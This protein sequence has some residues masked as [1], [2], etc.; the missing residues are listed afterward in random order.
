MAFVGSP[1]PNAIIRLAL[2]ARWAYKPRPGSK[3]ALVVE[4]M[5]KQQGTTLDALVKATGWLPHTT[6]AAL[7]GLR[8][9]GFAVDR[10]RSPRIIAAIVDGTAPADLT[11]TG[12]AKRWRGFAGKGSSRSG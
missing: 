12:L 8:K 3:Q 10:H 7:T 5:S 11:V 2:K 1:L 9:R 4:M 6:R